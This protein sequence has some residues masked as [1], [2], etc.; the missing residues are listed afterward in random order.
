VKS[1]DGGGHEGQD[2]DATSQFK[3]EQ[4]GWQTGKGKARL[5]KKRQGVS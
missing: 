4:D 5:D 1:S 2:K 3:N